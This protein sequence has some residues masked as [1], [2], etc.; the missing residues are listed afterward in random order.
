MYPV[1]D[2]VS[3]AGIQCFQDFSG[4]HLHQADGFIEF[5]KRLEHLI[6]S[7]ISGLRFRDL[8]TAR[9]G[10]RLVS[11]PAARD[12]RPVTRDTRPIFYRDSRLHDRYR[13]LQIQ[14]AAKSFLFFLCLHKH[15][16][17]ESYAGCFLTWGVVPRDPRPLTRDPRPVTRDPRPV[18]RDPRRVTRDPRRVPLDPRL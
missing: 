13:Q 5:C 14:M 16:S 18:T 8:R 2:T 11:V 9:N 4:P 6:F 12:P 1:C 3:K 10:E 15:K 7:P 17:A